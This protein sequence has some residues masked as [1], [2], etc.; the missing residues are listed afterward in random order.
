MAYKHYPAISKIV[1]QEAK[2]YKVTYTAHPTL[3]QMIYS[4][5]CY[6]KA[7]GNY[8]ATQKKKTKTN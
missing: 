4:F 3:P 2:K 1:R 8:D 5:V 7:V 6:M